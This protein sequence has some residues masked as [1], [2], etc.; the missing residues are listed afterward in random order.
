M[1]PTTLRECD[2]LR[3]GRIEGAKAAMGDVEGV[4]FSRAPVD[5]ADDLEGFPTGLA[6][7]EEVLRPLE[8]ARRTRKD[9]KHYDYELKPWTDEDQLALEEAHDLDNPNACLVCMLDALIEWVRQ[10]QA[11]AL[12]TRIP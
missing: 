3:R 11:I 6:P 8:A 4:T 10:R 1:E 12:G 9:C 5:F 2:L 7:W